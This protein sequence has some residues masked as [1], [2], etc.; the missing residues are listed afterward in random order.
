M[1]QLFLTLTI[2]AATLTTI[3]G[4]AKTISE[5][6]SL[7][8]LQGKVIDSESKESLAGVLI[9]I[10]SYKVYTDLD[11]N[12]SLELPYYMLEDKLKVSYISYEATEIPASKG[13]IETIEIKQ[14]N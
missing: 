2:L 9:C 7:V 12:F 3:A 13:K 14:V 10:S 1:K 4:N 6:M 8:S 11:G 5:E